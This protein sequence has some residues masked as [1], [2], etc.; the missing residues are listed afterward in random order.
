[1]PQCPLHEQTPKM[2]VTR[3]IIEEDDIVEKD[4][5]PPESE[6]DISE[7]EANE[8][9]EYFARASSLM[10]AIEEESEHVESSEDEHVADEYEYDD[11]DMVESENECMALL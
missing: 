8:A 2:F 3:E 4:N 7:T 9:E 5:S 1:M 6:D 11:V 10:D